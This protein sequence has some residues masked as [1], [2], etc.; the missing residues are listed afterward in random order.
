MAI[1]AY[2]QLLE[3]VDALDLEEQLRLAAHLLERAREVVAQEKPRHEDLPP[4]LPAVLPRLAL[5]VPRLDPP[6]DSGA[7][8]LLGQVAV[9]VGEDAQEWV[10]RTRREGDEQREAQWKQQE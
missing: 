1:E 3:Q 9:R 7:A 5:P 8:P 2:E 4:N 10:T 6:E